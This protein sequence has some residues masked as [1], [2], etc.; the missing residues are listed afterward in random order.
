MQDPLDYI[1]FSDILKHGDPANWKYHG[2]KSV[3]AKTVNAPPLTLK[4]YE[5]YEDEFGDLM[6]I[7]YF[8]HS[9]GTVSN[10]KV[11]S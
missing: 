10:V 3:A 2:R 5:Y 8:R 4:V 7:H 9:D 6:E 11:V 1:P